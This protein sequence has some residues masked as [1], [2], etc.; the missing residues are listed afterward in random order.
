MIGRYDNFV[1]LDADG[2]YHDRSLSTCCFMI[3]LMEMRPGSKGITV[4]Q[5]LYLYIILDMACLVCSALL[6][7][8]VDTASVAPADSLPRVGNSRRVLYH[9]SLI[10]I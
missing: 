5:S 2:L 10:H 6:F 4:V 7:V 1:G 8:S 3:G 9:L